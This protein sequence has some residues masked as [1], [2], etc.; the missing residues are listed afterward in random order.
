MVGNFGLDQCLIKLKQ[1]KYPK[2]CKTIIIGIVPET[3][4]RI[5]S[6]KHFYEYGNTLH[7]NLNLFLKEI[8]HL[9]KNPIKNK[10]D[11][12]N[13]KTIIDS[14]KKVIISITK[15]KKEM[16]NFPLTINIF[17]NN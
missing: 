11:Y 14:L 2:T 17:K 10:R 7:S 16:L 3:I 5:K 6:Q 13:L 15:F 8:N 1:K 9:I 4:T 12:Q